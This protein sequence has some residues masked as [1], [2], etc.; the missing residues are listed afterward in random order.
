MIR[1]LAVSGNRYS[2]MQPSH[3][4][5]REYKSTYMSEEKILNNWV[6]GIVI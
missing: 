4:V 1:E 3:F 6:A 5:S 2:G